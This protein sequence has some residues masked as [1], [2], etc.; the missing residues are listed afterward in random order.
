MSKKGKLGLLISALAV[1]VFIISGFVQKDSYSTES[2][3][4]SLWDKY[5]IQSTQFDDQHPEMSVTVY[6]EKDISKVE[7]YLED[8]LSKEDLQNYNLNVYQYSDDIKEFRE[9][10]QENTNSGN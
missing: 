2:V 7:N 8:N 5:S 9:N 10:A 6:K 3:M 1:A 4:D